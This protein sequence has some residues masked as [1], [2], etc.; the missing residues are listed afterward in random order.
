MIELTER[1][2]LPRWSLRHNLQGRVTDPNRVT[3]ENITG[4]HAHLVTVYRPTEF[5]PASWTEQPLRVGGY[6]AN[7]EQ[8]RLHAAQTEQT[9]ALLFLDY[10]IERVEQ[11]RG[12]T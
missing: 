10:Y 11:T 12:A 3:N 7:L 2:T 6:L 1:N 9:V 5:T 4:F 8:A